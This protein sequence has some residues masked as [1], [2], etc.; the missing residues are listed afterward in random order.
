MIRKIREK[1]SQKRVCGVILFATLMSLMVSRAY[2]W[3]VSAPYANVPHTTFG[4]DHGYHRGQIDWYGGTRYIR[5]GD[6]YVSWDDYISGGS[7]YLA[8]V[9]H[10]FQPNTNSCGDIRVGPDSWSWS[11]LPS[12]D[13]STKGCWGGANNEWRA[14][15]RGPIVNGTDYYFQHLFKDTNNNVGSG[16]INTDTYWVNNW[17]GSGPNHGKFWHGSF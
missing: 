17:G 7:G 15:V 3:T 16:E 14:N 4:A 10:A 2:A 12:V 6:D 5:A 8:M 11:N 9:Y 13:F 1:C